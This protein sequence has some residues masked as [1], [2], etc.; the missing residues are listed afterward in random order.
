MACVYAVGLDHDEH[1]AERDE[2]M[3]DDTIFRINSAN[4]F[5]S[6]VPLMWLYEK[7]FIS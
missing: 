7:A 6:S 5:I 2:P 3:W 1:G 4:K